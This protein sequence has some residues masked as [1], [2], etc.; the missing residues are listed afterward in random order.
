MPLFATAPSRDQRTAQ[1]S[2]ASLEDEHDL[3]P[4]NGDARERPWQTRCWAAIARWCDGN[5]R[6]FDGLAILES[7][8]AI[9]SGIVVW[10]GMW[11]LIDNHILSDTALSKVLLILYS[12][13]S[14]YASRTLYPKDLAKKRAEERNRRAALARD[15]MASE[16]AKWADATADGV[17]GADEPAVA[18]GAAARPPADE[19]D[20]ASGEPSPPTRPAPG[21]G[22]PDASAK[23]V[24]RRLYFDAPPFDAIRFCRASFA[25]ISSLT[26]W[27]GMWDLIDYH[28]IPAVF[29]V[30]AAD[31][32]ECAYVKIGCVLLG[33]LG[34]YSTRTLYGTD[35]VKL[36][37]FARI[38]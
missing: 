33:L 6:Y 26:L 30:C 25:V 9:I 38:D 5:R 37:H 22:T 16:E 20:R 12:L 17:A 29:P 27:I 3:R 24:M 23:P 1:N 32:R 21:T 36:A 18:D 31:E 4:Y 34:L 11:D 13:A 2:S 8:V 28:V 19:A 10:L 14:L 7:L 15:T 35:S